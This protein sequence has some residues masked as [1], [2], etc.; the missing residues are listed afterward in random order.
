MNGEEISIDNRVGV[1][2]FLG[3]LFLEGLEGS[4]VEGWGDSCDFVGRVVLED[5]DDE[6]FI[7][8]GVHI[9]DGVRRNH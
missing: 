4:V 6:A 3:G 9:V 1:W 2:S 8:H 7:R 5:V